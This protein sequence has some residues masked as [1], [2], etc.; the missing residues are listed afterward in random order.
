MIKT[1][2]QSITTDVVEDVICNKCGQS[3]KSDM[4]FTGL[5]EAT[6][7]GLYDSP[8]LTDETAYTFSLCEECLLDLFS[9]FKI[10]PAETGYSDF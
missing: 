10:P 1:S 4:N 3:L 8:K 7:R 5:T 2:K 6:V 9:T